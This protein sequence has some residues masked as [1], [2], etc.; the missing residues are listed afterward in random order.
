LEYYQ[1]ENAQLKNQLSD[2]L[3][4]SLSKSSLALAEYYQNEF[5][6]HDQ[7]IHLLKIALRDQM[8]HIQMEL[9]PAPTEKDRETILTPGLEKLRESVAVL[10]SEFTRLKEAFTDYLATARYL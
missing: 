10:G 4:G 8:K 2:A 6:R 9:L 7:V 1:F 3:E 5:L